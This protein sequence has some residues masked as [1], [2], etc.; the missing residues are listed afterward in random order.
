MSKWIETFC[1]KTSDNN[2]CNPEGSILIDIYMDFMPKYDEISNDLFQYMITS[3]S[4]K[5]N[6]R[7]LGSFKSFISE[8]FFQKNKDEIIKILIT[9]MLDVSITFKVD[10]CI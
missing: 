8:E 7:P 2:S 6:V 5:I 3:Y 1:N 4:S 9:K 10:R